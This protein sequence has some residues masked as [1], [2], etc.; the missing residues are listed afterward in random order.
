MRRFALCWLALIVLEDAIQAAG[1]KYISSGLSSAGTSLH[2]VIP[3]CQ[4][5][6]AYWYNTGMAVMGVTNGFET[7]PIGRNFMPGPVTWSCYQLMAGEIVGPRAEPII[8]LLLNDHVVNLSAKHLS[9]H[10]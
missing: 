5:R 2:N 8:V 3:T 10:L 6:Q 9:L 1:G 4:T 7:C